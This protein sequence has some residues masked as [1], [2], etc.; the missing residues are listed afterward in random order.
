M[1]AGYVIWKLALVLAGGFLCG[2]VTTVASS[3]AAISLPIL[4]AVGL[5]PLTANATNRLPVIAA[6][7]SATWSFHKKRLIDWRLWLKVGPVAC[8]GSTIG[9]WS[10][11]M[12]TNRELKLAVGVA[13]VVALSLLVFKVRHAIASPG[14]MQQRFGLREYLV[15]LAIGLW[16]GFI[17]IDGATFL[18]LALTLLV[19][20]NLVQANALKSAIILPS[21]LMSMAVFSWQSTI[22]WAL[23]GVLSVGSLIG[24][25]IGARLATSE[26]AKASI[27]WVLAIVLTAEG[28]HL[29]WEYAFGMRI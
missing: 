15:F 13:V 18:L 1:L 9:A 4:I 6:S 12:V 26:L 23:G 27:F 16:L 24:G 29:L 2:L 10:A 8:I 14:T 3:G 21:V 25:F 19:G 28:L 20:L 5:D 7:L 22:D 17:V 11:S